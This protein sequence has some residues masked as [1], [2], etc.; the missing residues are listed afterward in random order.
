MKAERERSFVWAKPD[1]LLVNGFRPLNPMT[2]FV[3]RNRARGV[4]REKKKNRKRRRSGFKRRKR[5]RKI[6][7]ERSNRK[8]RRDKRE[9]RKREKEAKVEPEIL[10]Y[11]Q[12]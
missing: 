1:R 9:E 5:K 10:V 4:E 6:K 12:E 2:A 8:I 7:R 3:A 11:R